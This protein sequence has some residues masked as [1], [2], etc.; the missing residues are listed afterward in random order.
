[1]IFSFKSKAQVFDSLL[2]IYE[3]QFPHEKIHIHFDRTMYNT[4]ETIFYKLYVLSGM[5]W[6]SLSKNVYVNWYDGNGNY[7]KQTAAPLFQSS[8]KGSFEIPANYKGNFLRVKAY[9]RWMLNEDSIFLYEKNIPINDGVVSKVKTI[10]TP[11]TR[12]DIFPE[13]GNFVEGLINKLAFKATNNFGTPVFIKGFLVNDKN[14]V[15]DTLK[16]LHDG[17]GVFKLRPNTGEK[18]YLNWTD[19]NGQKGNSPIAAASKEGVILKI[20]MDNEKAYAQVERTLD[21]PASYKHMRL[22]VHQNQHLIYNVEFKGEE[23]QVQKVALPIDELPTGVVQFSLFT[24]DWLPIAERIILVNNRLHEYNAN[25]NVG[26]AN[27]NKRGKNVLEII[28]KDTAASNM[29]IAITD[30]SIVMPEQQTI[31]SDFLLSSDIKGKVYNPAYYFSSDADSIAAHLD[32]VMLTNGWR[33]FD[34]A[35]LKA[36]LLPTLT[37]PRET[38]LMKLTGK[39]YGGTIAKSTDNLLLNLI[40]HAKDSSNKMLFVP[41]GKDGN[42]EDKSVFYYDTSRIYYSLNGKS[43]LDNQTVVRFENGLLKQEFAKIQVDPS[44]FQNYTT[45]SIARAKLNLFL[46]EQ[47]KQRKL[48]ASIT[49]AEVVVKARVKSPVQLLEE[50]YARGLFAGGDGT[51]FDLTSDGIAI[52][53]VD[54]LTFLQA[55]VPGLNISVAGSQASATWRGSKTDFFVNEFSTPIE[56]IQNMNIAEIAFIKAI[57]PPFFGSSGGGSGGSG[58]AIAIYTKRGGA[59]KG[60]NANSKGMENIVLGGYSVFKEFFHPEYDKP[61]ASF[62]TDNRTTLYWNPYVLTNK[63]SPRVRI[64]FY[65]ND[66][67]KKL[68]IVLEGMNADGKLTRVVKSIE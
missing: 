52:A 5:E 13:G 24:N 8:A 9:T 54:V 47:E 56:Q 26:I 30:A 20:S 18:Y 2:N 53:A 45:D 68:Q 1:M 25:L 59:N 15:L 23:R 33:R 11:K 64:E 34:W 32:L 43:K 21:V 27:I 65:N 31:Y 46:V 49:L 36:G 40:I 66:I 50:K 19:E 58:G 63:R 6:T 39:L 17:M 3:E 67:S 48:L 29:S 51:S 60:S 62:E 61:T 44:G 35:K 4:G 14:K 41:V 42:F 7:I 55:K 16:V 38:E 12:V 37:Y 28:V 10:T 22:I 57:R